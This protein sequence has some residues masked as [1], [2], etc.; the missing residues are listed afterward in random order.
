MR[1]LRENSLPNRFVLANNSRVKHYVDK[2]VLAQQ[3]VGA[4]TFFFTEVMALFRFEISKF[5]VASNKQVKNYLKAMCVDERKRVAAKDYAID[6]ESLIVN[7]KTYFKCLNGIIT[8]FRAQRSWVSL[9]TRISAKH[10]A[11]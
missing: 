5:C 6:R 2:F 4:K 3:I 7:R 9:I 11:I 8:C 10:F 1:A